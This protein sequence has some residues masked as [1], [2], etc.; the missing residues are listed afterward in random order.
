MKTGSSIRQRVGRSASSPKAAVLVIVLW[1]AFGLV[2]IALY[3]G[4]SMMFNLQAADNYEASVEECLSGL[5][6]SG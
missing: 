5:R 6:I 3:F 1:I 2:S 4:Q